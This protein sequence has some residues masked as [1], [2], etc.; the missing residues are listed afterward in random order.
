MEKIGQKIRKLR[1]K[2]KMPLRKLA[3]LLDLDQSTLS[4]IERG[5]RQANKTM[6]EQIASIFGVDSKE[7]II[8][9]FS[10]K[11]SYQLKD[12]ELSYEILKVAEQKIDYLKKQKAVALTRR[13]T[14]DACRGATAFRRLIAG[15][16]SAGFAS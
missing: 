7:L 6:V 11:L 12:E 2:N 15:A 1:I 9:F 3:A 16:T 5:T 14:A 4:K 10:D 13:T 8:A